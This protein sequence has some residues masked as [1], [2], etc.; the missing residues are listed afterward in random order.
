[1]REIGLVKEMRLD[2][3]IYIG[4][5]MKIKT[6]RNQENINVEHILLDKPFGTIIDGERRRG[7]N[8]TLIDTPS[9]TPSLIRVDL[10]RIAYKNG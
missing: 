7:E 5:E 9:T 3:Y 2:T 6:T 10:P 1:M 8:S 4:L